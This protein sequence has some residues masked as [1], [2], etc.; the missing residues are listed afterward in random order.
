MKLIIAPVGVDYFKVILFVSLAF[1][2]KKTKQITLLK[3]I[4]E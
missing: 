4:F 3:Y 2:K 1:L